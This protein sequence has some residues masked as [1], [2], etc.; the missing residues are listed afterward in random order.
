MGSRAAT[1]APTLHY[2]TLHYT[3]AHSGPAVASILARLP[4][5]DDLRSAAR[6]AP[7]NGPANTARAASPLLSSLLLLPERPPR[8]GQQRTART[9]NA[10]SSYPVYGTGYL[11]PYNDSA[12]YTVG[13][14]VTPPFRCN[15]SA[16]PNLAKHGLKYSPRPI[17]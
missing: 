10:R 3:L 15:E 16:G 2:T 9:E 12:S 8:A 6:A 1:P 7:G 13:S 17:K 14:T 4:N 5:S 11:F